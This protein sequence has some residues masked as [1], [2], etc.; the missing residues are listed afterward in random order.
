MLSYAIFNSLINLALDIEAPYALEASPINN[1]PSKNS[2][3][4]TSP[5]LGPPLAATSNMLNTPKV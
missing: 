2:R 4:L 3:A 1:T 5:L